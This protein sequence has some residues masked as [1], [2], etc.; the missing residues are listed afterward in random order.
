MS[1][2]N[3]A[4]TGEFA[5]CSVFGTQLAIHGFKEVQSMNCR[6]LVVAALL[7]WLV[8]AC[9]RDKNEDP[10]TASEASQALE[11][12]TIESQ[13]QALASD[14]VEIS[15]NFTI[16]SA[17]Q[18]AAAEL[19]TF[20][21]S[22]LPC[23]TL[24]LADHTLTIDYGTSGA[25]LYHG[26]T[27]TG[28]SQVTIAQND[29]TQVVVDHKWTALS[30][31][32]VKLDGTAEVTWNKVDPSRH[33][34]HDVTITRLLDQKTLESSGDRLQKPL[35]GGITEG[36]S[37]NGTRQWKSVRG[38]WDLSIENIQMRWVDPVPQAGQ[39]V[40]TTPANKKVTLAFARK[41]ADTITVTLSGPKRSFSSDVTSTG[42]ASEVK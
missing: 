39:Y 4:S 5:V 12:S 16:G 21:A 10:L 42:A 15:T 1:A 28:Q 32:V 22:Q 18:A 29:A 30:N 33:V 37:V 9:P 3:L 38:T 27:I 25:C 40:L 7:P 8:T 11:E 20:V 17:V 2:G 35:A 13:G 24:T 34:V 36:I 14:N 6:P 41:D 19:Q 26:H 31:G 23:A